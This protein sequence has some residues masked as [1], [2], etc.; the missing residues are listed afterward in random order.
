MS[1]DVDAFLGMEPRYKKQTIQKIVGIDFSEI[2]TKY[3]AA[4]DARHQANLEVSTK[5]GIKRD[6]DENLIEK[7]PLNSK[8]FLDK[9]EKALAHNTRINALESSTSTHKQTVQE[10]TLAI[11]AIEESLVEAKNS[12]ELVK[13]QIIANETA[14]KNIEPIPD[15]AI[16]V[17][18][19]D[20]AR[21]DETN[22]RIHEAKQCHQNHTEYMGLV[23][24]AQ[25]ADSH[26]KAVEAE[27]M[28]II[29]QNPLPADGMEITQD[30]LMLNGLPFESDQI[31][32][33]SKIIAALQI[34]HSMLGEVKFL[35]F[36]ASALDK[37]NVKRVN[38]WARK[39]GLQLCIERA[40]W[41]G[42]ELR[43][44][45]EEG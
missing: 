42:G 32:T 14:L 36:D 17:H 16:Q 6:Y 37:E 40:L 12:L 1:F 26:V 13:A 3:Q 23:K 30:G 28:E 19:D 15:E 29:K 8:D 5:Q 4:Y 41:E 45:I 24:V 44:E 43:F 35:H 34:A 7:E 2:D 20:V 39:H 22:Q 25:S 31:S 21:V 33:S 27:R 9:I 38:L 11:Q 18:R 10:K